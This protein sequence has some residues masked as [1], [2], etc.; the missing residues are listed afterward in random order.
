[1]TAV[2]GDVAD[3]FFVHPFSTPDYVRSTTLPALRAGRRGAG[4]DFELA[5]PVMVATGDTD[6]S[7]ADAEVA[8]RAQIAFYASTPAYRPVLERHDRGEL[9][10]ALRERTKSDDWSKLLELVDDDLFDLVA[11]RGTP[12][13]CGRDLAARTVG[14]VD[15]VAPNAP[16]ASD[17]EIWTDVLKAFRSTVDTMAER[18]HRAPDSDG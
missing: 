7:R 13:E 6:A 17:P 14:L 18:R 8:T 5:W 1:M 15:R 12:D 10:P 16:Y 9:Q 2:A 11:I 3:G 4:N